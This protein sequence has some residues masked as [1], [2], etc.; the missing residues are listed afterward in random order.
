MRQQSRTSPPKQ[1]P[2]HRQHPVAKI[3]TSDGS[4]EIFWIRKATGENNKTFSSRSPRFRVRGREDTS[5]DQVF[6]FRV[7]QREHDGA[8][9]VQDGSALEQRSGFGAPRLGLEIVVDGVQC[10][11][12]EVSDQSHGF[13]VQPRKKKE[14]KQKHGYT[15]NTS[16]KV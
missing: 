3:R 2:Y 8:G 16:S 11:G 15:C 5:V 4:G 7:N 9:A 13:G 14:R 12:E 10:H 1:G 6:Q